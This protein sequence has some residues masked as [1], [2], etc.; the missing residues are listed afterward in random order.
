M[1]HAIVA[2]LSYMAMNNL[3]W[4]L[5]DDGYTTTLAPCKDFFELNELT[6]HQC[7]LLDIQRLCAIMDE[8]VMELHLISDW[9]QSKE[10]TLL[11]DIAIRIG[12]LVVY[13]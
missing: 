10:A 7:Q 1:R 8:G 6:V 2:G 11:R 12:I 13:H 3:R 4:K 9:Q 5:I